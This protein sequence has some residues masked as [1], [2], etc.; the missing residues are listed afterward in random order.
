MQD[1]LLVDAVGAA[2]A[3]GI[4]ERLFHSLRDT[5]GFPPT[6][7]L[8]KRAM[9]WRVADLQAFVANLP[10]SGVKQ[11]EPPQLRLGRS[12]GVPPAVGSERG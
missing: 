12:L 1:L 4:S 11:P 3:L 2:T 7:V 8:S 10:A 6:V 9:R 5:P